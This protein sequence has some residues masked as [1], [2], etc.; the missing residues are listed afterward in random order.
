MPAGEDVRLGPMTTSTQGVL[1]FAVLLGG[2]TDIDRAA[3][4]LGYCQTVLEHEYAFA[5]WADLG[6]ATSDFTTITDHDHRGPVESV[7]RWAAASIP[8]G[9]AEYLYDAAD[10]LALATYYEGARLDHQYQYVR[11]SDGRLVELRYRGDLSSWS[12]RYDYDELG[13]A[14]RIEHFE[15]DVLAF[16]TEVE[17]DGDSSLKTRSVTRTPGKPDVETLYE[18]DGLVVTASSRDLERQRVSEVIRTTYLDDRLEQVALLERDSFVA[19]EIWSSDFDEFGRK[20]RIA[21]LTLPELPSGL[22]TAA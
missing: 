15:G 11:D 14:A 20:E 4:G 13:R 8:N 21:T 3:P 7:T 9:F 17:F 6:V 1:I 18:V 5:G 10:R 2:C 16:T 12:T 22:S 19:E